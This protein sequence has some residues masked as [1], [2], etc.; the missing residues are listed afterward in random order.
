MR[1]LVWL[2]TDLR[3]HDNS[4]L[5]HASSECRDGLI[6]V[7]YIPQTLH[8]QAHF[9][10]RQYQ[11]QQT[12]LSTLQQA[13]SQLNIPFLVYTVNHMD[14]IPAQLLALMQQHQLETLYYNE[15]YDLTQRTQDRQVTQII[16][17]AQLSVKHYH[18][19][20]IA[21]PQALLTPKEKP[22]TS[23]SAF[24]KTWQ[25]YLRRATLHPLGTV[26]KQPMAITT[27]GPIPT[28]PWTME[29]TIHTPWALEEQQALAILQ[30]ESANAWD[31]LDSD[32]Y[33]KHT[34]QLQALFTHLSN[35][36]LSPRQF[37]H[38]LLTGEHLNNKQ[39]VDKWLSL[40]I[41]REFDIHI[42]YHFPHICSGHDFTPGMQQ[43]PWDNEPKLLTA[44][45]Q[46]QTGYPLIDASMRCLNQTGWLPYDLQKAC[47]LFFTKVLFMDY[48][49]GE[50]Y[51]A[52]Q[53]INHEFASN[54]ALWQYCASTGA[55]SVIYS[56]IPQPARQSEIFDS[57]GELIRRYCPEL[58]SIDAVAI[59]DPHEQCKEIALKNGYA[60]PIVDY[61]TMRKKT[62]YHFKALNK[63]AKSTAAKPLF[64]S[65][66]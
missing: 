51:F 54:N 19:Q 49:L 58:A 14:D 5:F 40:L 3:Q 9:N 46:G 32:T 42:M 20:V 56:R 66:N 41:A 65:A 2:R 12:Q 29:S 1:G 6:V 55:E 43:L 27:S 21:P 25:G 44:W 35:G 36:L 52:M 17:A 15:R 62:L 48:R 11:L 57:K 28:L 45:Q 34:Q 22:F 50:Q 37:V 4:A 47:A 13:L 8:A 38:M 16:S 23:L 60:Q 26:E 33:A 59:H 63:S 24:K 53:C 30:Q 64:A 39:E 61:S 10:K 7:H 31:V 18:D